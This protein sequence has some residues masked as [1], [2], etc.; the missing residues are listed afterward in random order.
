MLEGQ[1]Q[2][3]GTSYY[4]LLRLSA[5]ISMIS[6]INN[7]PK[8]FSLMLYQEALGMCM[9]STDFI[10]MLRCF[11]TVLLKSLWVNDTALMY[12]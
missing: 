2:V 11:V 5:Q 4:E 3:D 6:S 8:V 10:M 7:L 1:Q 9:G 12:S